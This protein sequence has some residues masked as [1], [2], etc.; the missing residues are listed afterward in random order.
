MAAPAALSTCRARRPAPRRRPW[1]APA[2]GRAHAE[3]HPSGCGSRSAPH[4]RYPARS[5][6]ATDGRAVPVD[7][8]RFSGRRTRQWSTQTATAESA[9]RRAARWREAAP[10]SRRPPAPI[11]RPMP[12]APGQ[13]RRW[14]GRRRRAPRPGRPTDT[15]QAPPGWAAKAAAPDSQA[16]EPAAHSL[17][18]PPHRQIVEVSQTERLLTAPGRKDHAAA[19]CRCGVGCRA[20]ARIAGRKAIIIAGH[21][22]L[23]SGKVPSEPPP[24]RQQI[25]GVHRAGDG[26]ASRRVQGG[27]GG[28]ALAEVQPAAGRRRTEQRI[29]A[30]DAPALEEALGAVRSDALQVEQLA[31]ASER[32]QQLSILLAEPIG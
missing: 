13:Y 28:P 19:Q 20:A 6:A 22:Q 15:P 23:A 11:A 8:R 7:R 17:L 5:V 1:S 2:S 3:R 32:D 21:H 31:L 26:T 18:R 27:A 14:P 16:A 12:P 10:P 30:L 4:G 24:R 9:G 25:A 29:T